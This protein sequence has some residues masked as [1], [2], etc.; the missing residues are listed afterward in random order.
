MHLG[1]PQVLLLAPPLALSPPLSLPPTGRS[2]ARLVAALVLLPP[3]PYEVRLPRRPCR[4]SLHQVLR[5][6]VAQLVAGVHLHR[7][8]RHR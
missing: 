4:R 2:L 5:P 6:A 1:P 3:L 8:S 7:P